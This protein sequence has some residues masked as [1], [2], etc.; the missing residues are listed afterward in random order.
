MNNLIK[1]RPRTRIQARSPHTPVLD[2]AE[3]RATRGLAVA[4][5]E[6]EVAGPVRVRDP[7]KGGVN[8]RV[9]AQDVAQED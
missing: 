1:L 6:D 5:T 2:A 8:G 7:L 4:H 9:L 3:V